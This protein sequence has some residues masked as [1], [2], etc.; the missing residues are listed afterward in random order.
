MFEIYKKGQGTTARWITAASLLGLAA[1]GAFELENS[2][3]AWGVI[4]NAQHKDIVGVPLSYIPAAVLFIGAAL[5]TAYVVNWPRFVDYLIMSE[6]ELRKVSWPT[7]LEL[8]R[9]T[10][11]VIIT[12]LFFGVVLLIADFIIA[13]GTTHIYGI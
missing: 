2:A 5:L 3:A 10:T 9:Q 6:A 4:V 8:K 12:I 13:L 11:V 7:R 1:F